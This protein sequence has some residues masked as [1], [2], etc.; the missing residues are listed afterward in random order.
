MAG[1]A[2]V[3]DQEAVGEEGGRGWMWGGGSDRGTGMAWL[4]QFFLKETSF[5]NLDSQNPANAR[6]PCQSSQNPRVQVIETGIPGP[7]CVAKLPELVSAG[8]KQ[9]TP[10]QCIRQRV[11]WEVSYVNLGPPRTHTPTCKHACAHLYRI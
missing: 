10:L 6:R 7:S 1:R 11:I 9:E 2:F 4:F 5:Q 3:G 8:F